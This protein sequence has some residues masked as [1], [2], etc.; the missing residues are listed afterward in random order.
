MAGTKMDK[1]ETRGLMKEEPGTF[2]SEQGWPDGW[3]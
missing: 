3:R 2:L 1:K